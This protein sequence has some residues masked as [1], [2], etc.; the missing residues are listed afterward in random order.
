MSFR[1]ISLRLVVVTV[2]ILV[3]LMKR[4]K[5]TRQK[6][7]EDGIIETKATEL[8]KMPM[9]MGFKMMMKSMKSMNK[10]RMTAI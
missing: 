5:M 6:R 7:L 4:V 10:Q 8:Q 1:A 3:V 9:M 2:A